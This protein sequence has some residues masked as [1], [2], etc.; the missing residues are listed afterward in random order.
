MAKHNIKTRARRL[1]KGMSLSWVDKNPEK[2]EVTTRQALN[3]KVGH[4]NPVM[5]T[6]A[7]QMF[8]QHKNTI[9]FDIHL[10]WELTATTV[11][12]YPNGLEQREETTLKAYTILAELNN[13][14]LEEIER[15]RRYGEHFEHVEFKVKCLDIN[16]EKK[17]AQQMK[18]HNNIHS[19]ITIAII[20]TAL[21]SV[22]G[23]FNDEEN[24]KKSSKFYEKESR[25]VIP[26]P[27]TT[28]HRSNIHI[29]RQRPT[30][31]K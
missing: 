11:F 26:I 6:M 9:Y 2:D 4:K 20:A 13:I 10:L 3:F 1:V 27:G 21:S 31:A 12:K 24:S 22:I 25:K 30:N 23:I 28:L 16:P 29:R 18:R 7:D 8:K 19:L 14:I 17:K 5:R 15:D